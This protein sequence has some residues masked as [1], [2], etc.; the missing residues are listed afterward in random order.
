MLDE[1]SINCTLKNDRWIINWSSCISVINIEH[2][3]I[4]NDSLMSL[5]YLIIMYKIVQ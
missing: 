5:H 1:T 4:K 3:R 2:V